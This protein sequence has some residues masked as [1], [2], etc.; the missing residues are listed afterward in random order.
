MAWTGN[1]I[2]NSFRQELLEAKH[3]FRSHTFK[4][5]LYDE[6]A[7]LNADTTDYS[8]TNEVSGTGYSAGG[9][10]LTVTA[11]TLSG[12]VAIVD[13]ADAVYTTVTLSARGAL[14]YNS[15][16]EGG[17]GTTEAI[18][19]LDF[20]RL[21]TKTAANLTVVMPTADQINALLRL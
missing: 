3:D 4:L 14:M 8:V 5:A 13:F 21:I 20:G 9:I 11:P 2:C 12:G 19:V 10:A 1:H 15:T 6:D 7:T 16:T 17:G 18:M